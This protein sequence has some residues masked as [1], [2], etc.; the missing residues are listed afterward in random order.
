MIFISTCFCLLKI[1]RETHIFLR[2]KPTI[3]LSFFRIG[4]KAL[5]RDGRKSPTT[6]C[7][8]ACSKGKIN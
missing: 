3:Y 1:D 8:L 4:V 2:L 6:Y 7:T 5:E